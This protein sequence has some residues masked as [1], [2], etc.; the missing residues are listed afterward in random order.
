MYTI[1]RKTFTWDG[2]PLMTPPD[3]SGMAETVLD[4]VPDVAAVGEEAVLEGSIFEVNDAINELR[5]VDLTH[6]IFSLNLS[7]TFE[8][9]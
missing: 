6:L 3:V 8:V 9:R 4:G 2:L 7:K 5:V 1:L